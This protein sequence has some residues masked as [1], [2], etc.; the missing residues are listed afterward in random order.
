MAEKN[1]K[2][3]SPNSFEPPK[4]KDGGS[5]KTYNLIVGVL[6]V[7][8][9]IVVWSLTGN[10]EKQEK[11]KEAAK[12]SSVESRNLMPGEDAGRGLAASFPKPPEKTGMVELPPPKN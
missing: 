4:P 7:M 1:E 10:D 12:E 5:K 11:P 3:Q 2:E 8:A 6:A 9:L